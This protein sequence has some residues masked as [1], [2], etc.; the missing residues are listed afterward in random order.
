MN[1]TEH[2][3]ESSK[4]I[5]EQY[6]KHPFVRRIGDGTLD[7]EKFRFYIIQ[8][9]LYLIDY[10]KVFSIGAAKAQ[11]LS[12]MQFFSGY[13]N[14]LF[15]YETDIH[16]G[17]M[18]RYKITDDDIKNSRMSQAN[19]SYVSYMIRCAYEGG[20]AEIL[21]A[22][23]SCGI[24]YETIARR[25]VADNPGSEDDPFYGDWIRGYASDEFRDGNEHMK[26]L[27][28]KF[29]KDYSDE[30]IA[31]LTDIFVNCSKYELGFWNMAWNMEK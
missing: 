18:E 10:A 28:E 14:E 7:K 9:Y 11:D 29:T 2:F 5:W 25:I 3:L 26:T 21:A 20:A 13:A 23:L 27:I 8:D 24:S 19:L 12:T 31:H 6:H 30:Q 17:Y 22:V 1:I 4:E 15:A 16:K